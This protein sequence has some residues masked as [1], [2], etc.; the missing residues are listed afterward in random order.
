MASKIIIPVHSS[1]SSHELA[2]FLSAGGF[3]AGFVRH[4]DI[5]SKNDEF[6]EMVWALVRGPRSDGSLMKLLY[7]RHT[8]IET[9]MVV[10]CFET[11]LRA[12]ARCGR[13]PDDDVRV[14]AVTFGIAR[15]L[16]T[17][18]E[19]L[20]ENVVILV[21]GTHMDTI[22]TEIALG[23]MNQSINPASCVKILGLYSDYWDDKEAE[24]A[25][26]LF[27]PLLRKA[28]IQK[29]SVSFVRSVTLGDGPRP[30]LVD[31]RGLIDAVLEC[32]N[33]GKHVAF[34][35]PRGIAHECMIMDPDA[36]FRTIPFKRVGLVVYS[37]LTEQGRKVIFNP[38]AGVLV[39]SV[40]SGLLD[41][42][43]RQ[44]QLQTG[45]RLR[46]RH[47]WLYDGLLEKVLLDVDYNKE[48][49]FELV[50]SWPGKPMADI[51]LDLGKRDKQILRR[52]LRHLAV[53][54]IIEPHQNGFAL[55]K[56]KGAEMAKILP[57][58]GNNGLSFELASLVASSRY[59]VA[60]TKS[61]RLLIRLA[62]MGARLDDFLI[63][64]SPEFDEN[65]HVSWAWME[66]ARRH[67]AGPARGL[68]AAGRLRPEWEEP[69]TTEELQDVQ[70]QLVLAFIANL[71][72]WDLGTDQ[73]TL[74]SS[75][76]EV[77]LAPISLVVHQHM[78]RLQSIPEEGYLVLAD[79][80]QA[81]G[82]TGDQ[83][84]AESVLCMGAGPLK[85]VRMVLGE[86]AVDWLKWP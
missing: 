10:Q 32:V 39:H 42:R 18:S 17:Q 34:Y 45:D 86:S 28:G 76:H 11:R 12:E 64:L 13:L 82:P 24:R 63:H 50:R 65:Y 21:D 31:R 16:F 55:T 7:M 66:E 62:V 38:V 68:M 22:D 77:V 35:L 49:V 81:G 74:V 25:V 51:P 83:L 75:G 59:G 40:R 37:H 30:S 78:A 47:V 26:P 69:L 79:R 72:V 27:S 46:T 3:G 73:I 56:T 9:E 44:S 58:C 8:V 53:A 67:M 43:Q 4:R 54:G 33:Q 48:F 52:N 15:R 41:R 70:F 80:I 60:H 23:L 85:V 29:L 71:A 19:A 14:T 36:G 20:C 57:I 61:K 84:M 5:W 6:L 2:H 1:A